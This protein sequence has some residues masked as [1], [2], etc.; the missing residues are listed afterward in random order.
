MKQLLIAILTM[1]CLNCVCAQSHNPGP[2]S[3]CKL[4]KNYR[5]NIEKISCPACDLN[6]KKEKV[7]KVAEDKRR[8][9]II[10]A[11]AKSEKEALDKA[12]KD[13]LA[14]DAKKAE[15][16]KVFI[17]IPKISTKNTAKQVETNKYICK[18]T[19]V[20]WDDNYF[21]TTR[22][23]QILDSNKVIYE[24]DEYTGISQVYG[25]NYFS[26]RITSN[27]VKCV[28][29]ASNTSFL[30]NHKG[31]KITLSGID[32]F[33]FTAAHDENDD[34]FE[35]AVYTGKCTPVENDRYAKGDWHTIRY[36][37]SKKDLQLISS[38]PSWQHKNC[39]CQ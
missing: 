8:S 10:V 4:N 14:L 32:L 30:I 21:K 33:G 5:P 13:K 31:Q 28:A 7:A 20:P 11:K 6:D 9:D 1:F 19:F 37:F 24:S 34:Y 16:G 23:V 35:V 15:S 12:Y 2:N 27:L 17:N 22:N 3:N 18:G 26:L 39:E 36:V 29:D 25:T 38:K